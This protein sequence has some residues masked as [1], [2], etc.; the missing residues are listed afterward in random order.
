[1]EKNE[2]L[3]L[4]KWLNVSCTSVELRKMVDDFCEQNM[5]VKALEEA[6]NDLEKFVIS[7][8]LMPLIT[9]KKGAGIELIE[10][11]IERGR[12][13]RVYKSEE[14]KITERIFLEKANISFNCE[15][16]DYSGRYYGCRL[17]VMQTISQ[18]FGVEIDEKT[19]LWGAHYSA[20]Y[21]FNEKANE[22]I[23]AINCNN[24]EI[25]E[26]LV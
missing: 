4:F 8:K 16:I 10:N 21:F 19:W 6:E 14:L 1:M 25:K 26:Y 7:K 5:I 22:L 20:N 18:S 13:E 9:L 23:D 12:I 17:P 24:N 11:N 2:K 3:G 15:R